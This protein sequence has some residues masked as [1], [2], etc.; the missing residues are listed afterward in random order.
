MI[1]VS[2]DHDYYDLVMC[3]GID[4]SLRFIRKFV[5]IE[6]RSEIPNSLAK[7][8]KDLPGVYDFWNDTHECSIRPFIIVLCG[9]IY[10]GYHCSHLKDPCYKD[11]TYNV[12]YLP[13][14]DI[15]VYD[16]SSLEK[17][18]KKY[19]KDLFEKFHKKRLYF[20][21]RTLFKH[22]DLKE[23]F[24]KFKDKKIDINIHLDEKAPILYVGYKKQNIVYIK[25][26]VL[27]KFQ[28]YKVRNAFQVFQEISMFIGGVA[29]K[30][31]P[32]T[33]ELSE[34]DRIKKSGFDK[35]S[36]RKMGENSK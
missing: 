15:F 20:L 9:K 2:K 4:K 28:F 31:F 7:M 24:K 22:D 17:I 19:N 8:I 14:P 11:R 35:W 33:I 13:I 30:T 29:S 12:I 18:L 1:I 10:L 23:K 6:K 21:N 27:R 26:P 16:L 32:L 5:E 25:N 34:K 3:H 36:F